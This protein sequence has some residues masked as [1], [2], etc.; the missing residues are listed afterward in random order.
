MADTIAVGSSFAERRG[1]LKT[2]ARPTWQLVSWL[3]HAANAVRYDGAMAVNATYAVLNA[4]GATVLRHEQPF[5]DRCLRCGSLRSQT[6]YQPES[7][8]N[9]SLVRM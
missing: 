7:D 5:P 1:Y 3:T 2:Q 8:L 9:D 6:V 4:F